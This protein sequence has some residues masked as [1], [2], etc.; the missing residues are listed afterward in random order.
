MREG[1]NLIMIF[2]VRFEFFKVGRQII[3]QPDLPFLFHGYPRTALAEIV[4][5]RADIER[6]AVQLRRQGFCAIPVAR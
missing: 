3:Y 1:S 6:R 5:C 2:V 4:Q